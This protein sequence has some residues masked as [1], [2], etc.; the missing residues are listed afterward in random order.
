M[1]R[2]PE[3]DALLAEYP[4]DFVL[5]DFSYGDSGRSKGDPGVG[6]YTDAWGCHW[7]VGEPGVT[8]EVKAPVIADWSDLDSYKIPWEM[9]ERA[10]LSRVNQQCAESDG[11]VLLYFSNE[12]RPFER[13]QFLRGTE[14]LFLDLAYES[15]ELFL[16]RDMLHEFYLREVEMWANTDI[17]GFALDDDWGT[18]VNLLIPPTQWREIFKPLYREYCDILHSKGKFVFFHSDGNIESI[19]PDLIEIGVDALNCQLF[20]MDLERLADRFAGEITFWGEIDQQYVLPFGTTDQVREA[21]QRVRRAF[22]KGDGG[23]IA[24]CAWGLVDPVE[25]IEAV[26]DEWLLE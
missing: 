8:G 3:L 25:N 14:N 23:I 19:L 15:K 9:L 6:E 20:C 4:R 11:F 2:R 12:T 13:M 26:F 24:Q 17:D 21:V 5:P 1:F 7:V 22:A 16:L 10:D 18:Q